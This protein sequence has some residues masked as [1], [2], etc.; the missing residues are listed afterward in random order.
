MMVAPT[1]IRTCPRC[2]AFWFRCLALLHGVTFGKSPT[3][4]IYGVT[5]GEDSDPDSDYDD[6]PPQSWSARALGPPRLSYVRH[7]VILGHHNSG[8][9]LLSQYIRNHFDVA[10]LLAVQLVM[11]STRM[12]VQSWYLQHPTS[13]DQISVP[14]L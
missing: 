12:H 6:D 5:H 1:S 2:I 13:I 7:V 4:Y 8:T 3:G 9:H 10:L 14:L 11:P